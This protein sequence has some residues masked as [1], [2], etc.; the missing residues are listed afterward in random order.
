MTAAEVVAGTEELCRRRP[1][2]RGRGLP[3]GVPVLA[4]HRARHRRDG[5]GVERTGAAPPRRGSRAR[6][7]ARARPAARA[8]RVGPPLQS[9]GAGRSDRS[10]SPVRT[11][12]GQPGVPRR[13][14]RRGVRPAHGRSRTTARTNGPRRAA[15][16]SRARPPTRRVLRAVAADLP[17]GVR[18]GG[19]GRCGRRCG[20]CGRRVRVGDALPGTARRCRRRA[21]RP[22]HRA[23]RRESGGRANAAQGV[24]RPGPGGGGS[25]RGRGWRCRNRRSW[26]PEPSTTPRVSPSRCRR[27]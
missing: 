6:G 9:G 25:R 18:P 17:R 13:G 16:R 23:R 24:V 19:A 14:V 11:A 1:P 5:G 26:T 20:G 15:G 4:R 21:A 8:G 10:G 27:S 12:R 7:G 2:R 22:R 3:P